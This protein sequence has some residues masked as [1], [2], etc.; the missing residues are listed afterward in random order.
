MITATGFNRGGTLT[1]VAPGN[2]RVDGISGANGESCALGADT[3]G[4]C[5]LTSGGG[6]ATISVLVTSSNPQSNDAV[7]VD[8]IAAGGSS[9]VQ[10]GAQ[11]A[12]IVA[13]GSAHLSLTAR[14]PAP[15][16]TCADNRGGACNP[17]GG[18]NGNGGGGNP[19][20]R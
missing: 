9:L 2:W 11:S 20:G 8:V 12:E 19:R 16:N 17:G 18:G 4:S 7:S 14:A 3:E 1:V 13:S 5:S 6:S 10:G 15:T